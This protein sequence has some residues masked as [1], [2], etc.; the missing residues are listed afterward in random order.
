M[1][2]MIHDIHRVDDVHARPGDIAQ[3]HLMI[4][5][6]CIQNDGNERC[7]PSAGRQ[8]HLTQVNQDFLIPDFRVDGFEFIPCLITQ[9]VTNEDDRNIVFPFPQDVV[10][11]FLGHVFSPYEWIVIVTVVPLPGTAVTSTLSTRV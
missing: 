11:D 7:H 4:F 3:T 6:V 2:H 1:G 9:V 10:T 5:L 8:C